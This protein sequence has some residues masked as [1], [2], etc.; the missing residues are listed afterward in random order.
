M[1][2]EIM[3]KVLEVGYYVGFYI[4]LRAMRNRIAKANG[5]R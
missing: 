2:L 1:W 4:K 5:Y 3:S